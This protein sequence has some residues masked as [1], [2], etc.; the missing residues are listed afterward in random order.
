MPM[1]P[2]PTFYYDKAGKQSTQAALDLVLMKYFAHLLFKD[3][4][5]K[6]VYASNEFCFRERLRRL[7]MDFPNRQLGN[8]LEF[9]FMN[10]WQQQEPVKI[11]RGWRS[12]FHVL[13]GSFIDELGTNLQIAPAGYSY[14]ATA[15]F[16]HE[17][18]VDYAYDA[19]SWAAQYPLNLSVDLTWTP[20]GAMPGNPDAESVIFP[21]NAVVAFDLQYN[22]KYTD[23][24]WLAQERIL[25]IGLDFT[26]QTFRM[27]LVDPT[28][29]NF[30]IPTSV[31]FDFAN[32]LGL[33]PTKQTF[34]QLTNMVID[35]LLGTVTDPTV[36]T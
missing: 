31:V 1:V 22:P 19:L 7:A 20:T 14:Q 27:R 18:D 9:P 23:N 11:D 3:D 25:S 16:K 29:G 17:A 2:T 21:I 10:M 30:W 32:Q 12:P 33:D 26:I 24:D 13:N 36:S 6:L 15:F 34:D 28:A 8:S 35:Q 4:I 5:T